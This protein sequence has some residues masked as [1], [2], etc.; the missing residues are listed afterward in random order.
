M[1]Q[2]EGEGV[3][4][5]YILIE[6]PNFNNAPSSDDAMSSYLR[7]GAVKDPAIAANPRAPRASGEDLAALVTTFIDDTR[8]REGCP[9]YLSPAVRQ[10]ETRPPHQGRLARPLR[11][12]PD[13]AR[14]AA[15]R[16]RSSRATTRC[17]SWA[18]RT[19]RRGGTSPAAT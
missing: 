14:R 8:V 13:H 15:T 10:A 5:K 12:Q 9:D 18:A 4:G 16:S 6:A 11:R 2:K 17:S 1:G 3:L 7:L 19:T